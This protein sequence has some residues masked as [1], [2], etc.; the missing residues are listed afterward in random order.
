[1][2]SKSPYVILCHFG[3][4]FGSF[5][6]F[7]CLGIRG[8]GCSSIPFCFRGT[9]S[10]AKG[11]LAVLYN[12]TFE[13]GK[14]WNRT[15]SNEDSEHYRTCTWQ[16]QISLFSCSLWLSATCWQLAWLCHSGWWLVGNREGIPDWNYKAN[17]S[18]AS[19]QCSEASVAHLPPHPDNQIPSISKFLGSC[20][21]LMRH[22]PNGQLSENSSISLLGVLNLQPPRP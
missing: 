5:G 12:A 20:F 7:P 19:P 2:F 6:R 21:N 16:P 8:L 4:L 10:C 14:W 9:T 13:R 22:D 17:P 3:E 1:M 15:A 18:N 11:R